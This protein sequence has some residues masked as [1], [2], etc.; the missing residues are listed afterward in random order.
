MLFGDTSKI[1]LKFGC[2]GFWGEGKTGVKTSLSKDE[3]QQQTQPTWDTGTGNQTWTTLVGGECSHHCA[4]PAPISEMQ[5]NGQSLTLF[6][7]DKTCG[8]IPWFG[9]LTQNV[10]I[11]NKWNKHNTPLWRK[12]R[13]TAPLSA[14]RSTSLHEKVWLKPNVSPQQ[15]DPRWIGPVGQKF[16]YDL[17]A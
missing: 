9:F 10:P 1:E 11:R 17:K 16:L 8:K 5:K 6:R 14:W 3:N 15:H 7:Q 4:I 2:V 13:D 12:R